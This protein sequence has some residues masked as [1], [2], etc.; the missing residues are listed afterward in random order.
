[1]ASK[2]VVSFFNLSTEMPKVVI[3]AKIEK[4]LNEA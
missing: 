4:I 1:V 2:T 3:I